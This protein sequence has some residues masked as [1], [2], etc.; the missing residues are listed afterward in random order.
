MKGQDLQLGVATDKMKNIIMDFQR[1][2][3][4]Q[5]TGNIND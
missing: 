2:M 1:F 4:L 3:G 5:E